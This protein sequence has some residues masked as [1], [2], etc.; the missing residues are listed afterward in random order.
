VTVVRARP[1][2]NPEINLY[3]GAR[4]MVMGYGNQEARRNYTNRPAANII[5][6]T[7][8]PM[9]TLPIKLITPVIQIHPIIPTF[10]ITLLAMRLPTSP[11]NVKMA[12]IML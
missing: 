4:E 11:P 7:E 9:I 6:L 10:P 2:V 5:Q 1:A 3:F 8:P 12:V